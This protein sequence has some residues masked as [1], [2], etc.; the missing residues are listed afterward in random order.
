MRLLVRS[1]I[2]ERRARRTSLQMHRMRLS[3][4]FT[5][6]SF[7]KE[8]AI[9]AYMAKLT[10]DQ[11][12]LETAAKTHRLKFVILH[13]SYARG[14]ARKDSD[15]DIAVLGDA[16]IEF[17]TLMKLQGAFENIFAPREGQE[18][19]VKSLHRADPLFLHEVVRDGALLFGDPLEYEEF[20]A[21]ARRAYEDAEP[22]FRLQRH[23]VMKFQKYLNKQYG[24]A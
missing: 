11:K 22:L 2:I 13:G 7:F 10:Y 18:M 6:F 8:R 24:Q 3:V 21:Y 20:R 4:C 1:N 9:I 12:Q 19:D 5:H 14:Q 16:P 17:E 23:Q 15:I